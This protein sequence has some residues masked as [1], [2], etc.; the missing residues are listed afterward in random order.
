MKKILFLLFLPLLLMPVYAQQDTGIPSWI[1]VIAGAWAND[2]LTDIE[3]QEAIKFLIQ[4]DIIPM[5]NVIVTQKPVL[6]E[7]KRLSQLELDPKDNKIRILEKELEDYGADNSIMLL[8]ITEQQST[9]DSLYDQVNLKR[10]ELQQYKKDYPLKIG[11]IG[12]M[13]VVDYIQQLEDRISK[14]KR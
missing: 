3:F 5:D 6:D 10:D 9:I 1:K 7:Q 12:G 13:L 2:D 14:L 8:K 4:Q 11:N